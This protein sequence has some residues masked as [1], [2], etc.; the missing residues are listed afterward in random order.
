M[1][2]Y[3]TEAAHWG[4][5]LVPVLVMLAIFVWLDAFALMSLKEIF[6]L[7]ALGA[8]GALAAWPVSGRLLDTLPIGFS[9]YSRFIAPWIEEAIKAAIMIALFR[10]NRIGYKLDA[11]I[12]GFAIGAG[13]S[14]VENIFYLTLFPNYGTGTWLVRGFGTAIM[15]GTTLAVLAAIAHE[16]A[17]RETRE[18]AADYDFSLMWFVP[19][20]GVAV[21]LH[22]AFNQFPDRPMIS[23]MAAILVAPIALIATLNFG[24]AE[25]QRWLAAECAEHKAQVDTL[26]AGRWPDGP[27][28]RKIAAL[29]ERLDPDAVKRIRRYWELQAWLVAE[30]EET[31]M[32]EAAGDA[33]FDAAAVRAAFAELDGL[34]R[35]IGRSTFAAMQAL[36]PFSRNDYWEVSEL[37]QRVGRG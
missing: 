22:T 15:H 36:L 37:R 17:E 24:T 27:A 26:R 8:I 13:F 32:E 3:L 31:M 21:A 19:G 2:W 23:M 11:V 12:S 29:A 9:L 30:A 6:V 33:E 4:V 1:S 25:A 20:Y 5:A 7:L 10:M 14:L 34:R 18:A 28:G 16:F 35:A